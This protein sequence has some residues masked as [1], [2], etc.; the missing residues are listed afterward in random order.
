MAKGEELTETHAAPSLLIV[1][2]ERS[3][4]FTLGE[5]A[6]DA[7]L[8][9]IEA[10]GGREALAA[11]RAHAVDAVL[12]D[13]KLGE[14]DGLEVLKRLGEEDPALPVIMLTGHGTVS[15]AVQ[16]TRLGAYDFILKPPD[17]DH[18]GVVVRRAL[19]RARLQR[20]VEHHRAD[21]ERLRLVGESAGLKRAL[22][23][24]DRAAKSSSATVLLQGETGSGKELMA[25]Q[26]HLRSPRAQGPFVE[27]NC[28]AIPEHL[29]ESELF[30]HEKGAFTDAKHFKKG[31]FDLA[32]GG[33]L[34]LDEIGEMPGSLQAK[35]LRVL[36]TRSFR[37]VGGH[38][39]VVVDV[40]F[41]TATHRDL[42][43]EVAEGRF[44]EDLYFRLNVVPISMPPLRERT[45]DIEGLA[46]LFIE[47][48][49]A[50]LAR[51]PARLHADALAAL[52]R[53]PWP[54]NVRE[55][56]NVIE[57]VLLLEADEEILVGHLPA[58]ITGRGAGGAGERTFEAF[59]AGVVRTLAELE[60]MAIEH[61]LKVAE[62]NKTRAALLLG[63]SRQTLRTKLK[64]DAA[65]DE[66]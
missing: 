50:E 32:D 60:R 56:R 43:R 52:R 14:E 55:L 53:Y 21:R 41:V 15:H 3:L 8:R 45:E 46:R 59:P 16:A 19:E 6:R 11:L 40:R 37:R 39:D 34:F 12:L 7:G 28:S 13:L 4:R 64:E 66:E 49:C 48:Y 30:G 36:E 65:D 62:G 18:L 42:K 27:V 29:L 5:W 54:G 61:A 24:L 20:E 1:D 9:P 58:E 2:D 33:T 57:R 35:L 17:L 10:S 47:R 26:L 51:P 38:A 63:I 23:Q 44:R 25:W 22:A 31:L